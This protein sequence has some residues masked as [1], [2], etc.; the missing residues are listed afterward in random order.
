MADC[1]ENRIACKCG[2]CDRGTAKCADELELCCFSCIRSDENINSEN[3]PH[4]DEDKDDPILL[5][6]NYKASCERLTPLE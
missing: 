6:D 5:R 3:A 1:E 4:A 2:G